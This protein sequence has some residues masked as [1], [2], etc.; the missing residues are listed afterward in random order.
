MVGVAIAPGVS[1]RV[2]DDGLVAYVAST[3][4]THLLDA[5]AA[6]VMLCL[7]AVGR[8][9]SH[10]AL[11][12]AFLEPSESPESPDQDESAL[13]GDQLAAQLSRLLEAMV[14]VGVLCEVP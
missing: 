1:W 14:D 5:A 8:S 12:A 6:Q 10:A 9:S 7:P 2:F 4:K 11:I 3:A 13:L